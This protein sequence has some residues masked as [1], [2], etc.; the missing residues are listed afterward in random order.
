[1]TP[2][3]YVA[4]AGLVGCEW[5]E[6]PLGLSTF[7]DPVWGMPGWEI[8]SRAQGEHPHTGRARGMGRG[9]QSGGTWKG[10][11]NSNINKRKYPLK[12]EKKN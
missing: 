12:K 1:M 11:N 4:E 5:E 7:D 3:T 9:L 2:D 6:W 8:R 10:E